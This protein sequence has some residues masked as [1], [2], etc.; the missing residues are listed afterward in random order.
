MT[1]NPYESPR[2]V[3]RLP[4]TGKPVASFFVFYNRVAWAFCKLGFL[5]GGFVFVIG[6]I[7]LLR[8]GRDADFGLL[9]VTTLKLQLLLIVL[10][11]LA[12]IPLALLRYEDQADDAEESV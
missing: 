12:A 6:V 5:L 3:E 2:E 9:A 11:G 8:N 4:A 7:N 10:A 1:D